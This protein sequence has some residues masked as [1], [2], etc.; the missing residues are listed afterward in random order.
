M[1]KGNNGQEKTGSSG[2]SFEELYNWR[3]AFD[4]ELKNN[5]IS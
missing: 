1:P 2:P 5:T 4:E 3:R